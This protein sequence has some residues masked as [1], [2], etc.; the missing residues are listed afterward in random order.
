VKISGIVAEVSNNHNGSLWVAHQL[1]DAIREAGAH[2]LKFQCYTPDEL[3]RL[4]GDGPAP[5]PW[6][7]DGW[8]MHDLY[9]KAQTPHAWF[10]ELV[11]HCNAI[12]QPWFSSVFGPDSLALLE[13]LGCPVYKM[14]SLDRE[15]EDFRSL[16]YATGKPLIQSSPSPLT[17]EEGIV[18]LYCP[19]GYPQTVTPTELERALPSFRGFSYHGTDWAVPAYAISCGAEI[20]EC[21]VQ[22]DDVPSELEQD[23]SLI[24]ADLIMLM[25]AYYR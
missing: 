2:W 21:H 10:P 1:I 5:D 18:Q 7:A 13:S 9:T 25:E 15:Q 24:V 20:I 6:G 19:A 17:L 14:A 8:T 4:R 23:V 3:V 11:A 22:L 16:V 12:G